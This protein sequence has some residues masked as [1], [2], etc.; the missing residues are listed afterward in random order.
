MTAVPPRGGGK[1]KNNRPSTSQKA[2]Q[3]RQAQRRRNRIIGF[4]GIAIV[5]A[6]AVVLV[7][8]VTGG[9]ST[10]LRTPATP[11][12]VQ[13][14]TSVSMD[15]LKAAI[16]EAA[17]LVATCAQTGG[18]SDTA[19]AAPSGAQYPKTLAKDGKPTLMYIGAEF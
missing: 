11:A 10:P 12:Q 8:L 15:T 17:R 6:A 16:P 2:S 7:L 9:S 18:C 3:R 1:A 5:V 19:V 14:I 4:G 13:A